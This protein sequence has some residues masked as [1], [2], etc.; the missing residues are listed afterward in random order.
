MKPGVPVMTTYA[1]HSLRITRALGLTFGDIDPIK[2]F[3]IA[4]PCVPGGSVVI[5]VQY[6]PLLP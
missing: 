1:F 5:A 6:H 4:W 2:T 3:G